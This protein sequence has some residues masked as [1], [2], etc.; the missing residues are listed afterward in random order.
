M[1]HEE[2]DEDLLSIPLECLSEYCSAQS[3]EITP[4]HE[5]NHSKGSENWGRRDMV[6]A[7]SGKTKLHSA[8]GIDEFFKEYCL[9]SGGK[10][11]PD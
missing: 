2:S 11:A 5:N 3:E 1:W 7:P 9:S 6:P 8:E 4:G 10:L